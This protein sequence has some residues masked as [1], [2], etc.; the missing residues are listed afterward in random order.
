MDTPADAQTDCGPHPHR[1]V[2][3]QISDTRVG[4]FFILEYEVYLR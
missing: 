2:R 1:A 3:S 4:F